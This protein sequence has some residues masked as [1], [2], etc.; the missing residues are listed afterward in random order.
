MTSAQKVSG[1]TI[2]SGIR[3]LTTTEQRINT[4]N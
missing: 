3:A 1:L 2:Y 4:K